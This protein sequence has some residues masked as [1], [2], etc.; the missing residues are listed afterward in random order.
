[1]KWKKY[2]RRCVRRFALFPIKIEN[3]YRW[4]EVVYIEQRRDWLD[5]W[6]N[7]RFV[8]KDYYINDKRDRREARNG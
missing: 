6:K 2:G 5:C 4:F 7:V 1:M 8:S 3:E